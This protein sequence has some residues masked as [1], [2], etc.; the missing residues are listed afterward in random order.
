[1]PVELVHLITVC[2]IG[3]LIQRFSAV[4]KPEIVP[5]VVNFV[6]KNGIETQTLTIRYPM[7]TDDLAR[8]A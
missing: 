2:A 5:K 7:P 6:E 3:S 4:T 1:E 8:V